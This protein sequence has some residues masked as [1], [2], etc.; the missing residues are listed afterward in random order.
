MNIRTEPAEAVS[1]EVLLYGNN[2]QIPAE[3][4]A[5]GF[6]TLAVGQNFTAVDDSFTVAED[7]GATSFDVLA[8][9]SI[10]RELERFRSFLLRSQAVERHRLAVHKF[11]LHRTQIS[12]GRRHSHTA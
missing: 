12:R 6:A 5:Y 11:H 3:S 2:N 10:C 8:N 7:S 9:D 1:S 4:V